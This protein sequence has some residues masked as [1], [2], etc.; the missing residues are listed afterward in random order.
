MIMDAFHRGHRNF[1]SGGTCLEFGVGSGTTYFYQVTAILDKYPNSKLIG[2]DSWQGLP[3]ETDGVWYP[4]RHAEGCLTF[5]KQNVESTLKSSGL[6][7]D[8][9][10]RL[11][12]GFYEN[13]LTSELQAEIQDLVFVNIDVDIHKSCVE[14]LEFIRP[15]L[16]PGVN[17]YFDDWKDPIDK[18]EGKWGEHLAWEQFLEKYPSIKAETIAIAPTNQRYMEIVSV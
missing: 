4:D 17:L 11:V 9:R 14:L 15:M 3:K 16:R 18:F 1:P 12:D 10:F 13:T 5:P 8:P 7:D 2:F 6:W